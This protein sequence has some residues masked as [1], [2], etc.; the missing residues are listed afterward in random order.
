MIVVNGEER[1]EACKLAAASRDLLLFKLELTPNH[2]KSHLTGDGCWSM[3]CSS[4]S[5]PNLSFILQHFPRKSMLKSWIQL[6]QYDRCQTQ[7]PEEFEAC[8]P[9]QIYPVSAWHPAAAHRLARL[10]RQANHRF[11]GKKYSLFMDLLECFKSS[12]LMWRIKDNSDK[13]TFV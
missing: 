5:S 12:I 10:Y 8:R 7:R 4:I 6:S 13:G 9:F 11:L 2:W 3:R 1:E